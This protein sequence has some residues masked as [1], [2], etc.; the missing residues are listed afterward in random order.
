MD[1]RVKTG[2]VAG[3]SAIAIGCGSFNDKS[4]CPSIDFNVTPI[5]VDGRQTYNALFSVRDADGDL[6]HF[7]F[8]LNSFEGDYNRNLVFR[9]E[10]SPEH[11]STG[12]FKDIRVS[13]SVI[14]CYGEGIFGRLKS[15]KYGVVITAQDGKGNSATQNYT[16]EIGN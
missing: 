2:L 4:S 5:V 12:P 3:L 9:P 15:G 10:D 13:E 11:I 1:N 6:K 7:T 16:F 8:D 14:E